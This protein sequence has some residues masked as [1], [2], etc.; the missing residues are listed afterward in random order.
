MIGK[1]LIAKILGVNEE[2]LNCEFGI[3]QIFIYSAIEFLTIVDNI[4]LFVWIFIHAKKESDNPLFYSLIG[5]V[6]GLIGLIYYFSMSLVSG[7]SF[8]KLKINRIGILVIVLVIISILLGIAYR[9][10]GQMI[11]NNF[12]GNT[13]LACIIEYNSKL[14]YTFGSINIIA[15]FLVS[16]FIAFKFFRFMKELDIKPFIWIIATLILGIIPWIVVNILALMKKE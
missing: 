3:R 14:T 16:I 7:K 6:F 9:L 8:S 12:L 13:G 4:V 15:K 1:I 2:T 10:Q 11:L 5:L